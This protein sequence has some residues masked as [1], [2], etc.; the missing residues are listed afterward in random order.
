[1]LQAPAAGCQFSC[2]SLNLLNNVRACS[3]EEFNSAT[4]FAAHS[5]MTKSPLEETHF[6]AK[7]FFGI[8]AEVANEKAEV[9]GEACEIVI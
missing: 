2:S 3:S 9:A 6:D 5:A 8:L 1:M 7:E 4:S